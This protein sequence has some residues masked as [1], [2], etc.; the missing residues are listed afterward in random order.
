MIRLVPT[1]AAPWLIGLFITGPACAQDMEGIVRKLASTYQGLKSV[2]V[3]AKVQ[4]S[5]PDD[6]MNYRKARGAPMKIHRPSWSG[7]AMFFIQG[8]MVASDKKFWWDDGT[9]MTDEIQAWDGLTWQWLNRRDPAGGRLNLSR[10]PTE[11][12]GGVYHASPLEYGFPFIITAPARAFDGIRPEDGHL[13]HVTVDKLRDPMVWQSVV[14][15]LKG[16][17]TLFHYQGQPCWKFTIDGG[18]SLGS[19]SSQVDYVVWLPMAAPVYPVRLEIRVQGLN[20]LLGTVE[21]T[22]FREPVDIGTEIPLRLPGKLRL[23]Y[24]TN[25]PLWRNKPVCVNDYEFTECKVNLPLTKDDFKIDTSLATSIKYL[26]S[27]QIIHLK[28]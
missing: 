15:R 11:I 21:V 3:T 18:Y 26:D 20:S 25:D 8:G 7:D 16:K 1:A 9:P 4:S 17:V 6:F 27:G 14:K 5:H 23:T 24:Y 28:R 10:K 2:S 13:W 22:E 19:R 12:R